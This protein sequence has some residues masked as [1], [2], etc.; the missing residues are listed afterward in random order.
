MLAV[1]RLERPAQSK[2]SFSLLAARVDPLVQAGKVR[3][4]RA[5]LL[6]RG[7]QLRCARCDIGEAIRLDAVPAPERFQ[8]RN[9]CP[10]V[11]AMQQFHP[12]ISSFFL[13]SSYAKIDYM[14]IGYI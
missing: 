1:Q 4:P 7:Q 8:R 11:G 9:E 6:G 12:I 10:P 14:S 2:K 13:L 5:N 3:P